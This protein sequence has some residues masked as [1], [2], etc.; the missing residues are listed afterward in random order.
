M[1]NK[2]S[3]TKLKPSQ[4]C[5]SM[6]QKRRKLEDRAP[7]P[8]TSRFDDPD[9]DA[10][11]DDPPPY[12]HIMGTPPHQEM[13]PEDEQH[14]TAPQDERQQQLSNKQKHN[15]A[16]SHLRMIQS[17]I[18][19]EW[20]KHGAAGETQHQV[21]RNDSGITI[22]GEQRDPQINTATTAHLES[23][24]TLHQSHSKMMIRNIVFCRKCGCSTG[25][26]TQQLVLG[27]NRK[28][29]HNFAKHKLK[30]MLDGKHPDAKVQRWPD[31]LNT[32][33]ATPPINI[34]GG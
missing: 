8:I 12:D 18:T 4:H 33:V 21:N 29:K 24:P 25:R 7:A 30:R 16:S 34:E 17:S 19:D 15:A 26:K 23:F 32:S 5:T 10:D 13:P 11:F 28:P 27:C 14:Q 6:R 1:P 31:R 9:V 20:R 2:E 22:V 3:S